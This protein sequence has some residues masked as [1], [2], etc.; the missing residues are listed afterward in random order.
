MPF[1]EDRGAPMRV[2]G[3][4]EALTRMGHKLTVV[5][6]H[7]GRDIPG[8]RINRIPSL[9][10]YQRRQA[11]PNWHKTYLDALLLF[12][13]LK[14]L[15]S[16]NY[17][18]VHA[19]LHEGLLIANAL[20]QLGL[21]LPILFDAQG[22]LTGEMLAHEFVSP[23]SLRESI[24]SSLERRLVKS[25]AMIATSSRRLQQ[26]LITS[27]GLPAQRVT[28]LPDGVDTEL[29]DPDKHSGRAVRDRYG[30]DGPVIVYAGL[31]SKHQGI[32]FLI[33][34]VAPKVLREISNARFLIA[35]FPE[36]EYRQRASSLGFGQKFIFTGKVAYTELPELLA[37]ADVAV[38][39]K[40]MTSGEANQKVMT[41]M[42]MRLPIIALD[43]AYNHE[44]LG[45]A[46]VTSTP[47]KFAA[48]LVRLLRSPELCA[49]LGEKA[50]QTIRHDY[51]WDSA[52]SKLSEIYTRLL[53]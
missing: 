24:W 17:S 25:C 26:D 14:T 36:Q 47:D 8:I 4:C 29:F 19:H 21:D 1:F 5:S 48:D 49:T 31:L 32:D 53:S 10:W 37:A 50:R 45:S 12:K 20:R 9:P 28:Y 51:S 2:L 23:G 52:A 46:G 30:L 27:C 3:E 13:A 44:I 38:A 15:K 33:E 35:G 11:G 16:E 7:L 40:F 42:A 41:Y 34:N 18:I 6:Y 43:Y 22:S 39:P